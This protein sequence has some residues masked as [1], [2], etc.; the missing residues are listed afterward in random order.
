MRNLGL[1]SKDEYAKLKA[2]FIVEM[3]HL[4]KRE[5]M[6][7]HACPSSNFIAF[8]LF[9]HHAA[10]DILIVFNQPSNPIQYAIPASPR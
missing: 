7:V 9:T 3:R 10:N 2:D 4:S 1:A 8:F 5:S 6:L